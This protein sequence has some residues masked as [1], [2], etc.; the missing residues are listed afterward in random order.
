MTTIDPLRSKLLDVT[1]DILSM[2]HEDRGLLE[3]ESDL[4]KAFSD[5]SLQIRR[6]LSGRA[7]PPP[8]KETKC[9]IKLPKINV[10]MFNGNILN[11][12]VFWQQF[13]GAIQ[14]K[15]QL[16]DTEE[17]AYLRDALKDGPVRHTIES[18]SHDAE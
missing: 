5:L 17:V 3:H 11:W 9:G 4:N 1:R 14:G 7:A 16:D 15:A 12:N 2:E 18:L 10:P 8:T 13:D 6:L